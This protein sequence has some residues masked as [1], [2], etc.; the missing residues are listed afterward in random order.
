MEQFV[1]VL[2]YL[3]LWIV[4]DDLFKT[5]SRKVC[6]NVWSEYLS[7]QNII[8]F[9]SA[10]L[11][12][13]RSHQLNEDNP[14]SVSPQTRLDMVDNF[15]LY[16]ECLLSQFLINNPTRSWPLHSNFKISICFL[17]SFGDKILSYFYCITLLVTTTDKP[18]TA[19]PWLAQVVTVRLRT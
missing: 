13:C 4:S 14:A 16:C 8:L 3:W 15:S 6:E 11:V 9:K 17:I 1:G 2:C 12:F 5:A 18:S 7:I 19:K 10:R